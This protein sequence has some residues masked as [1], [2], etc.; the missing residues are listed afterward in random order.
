MTREE[1]IRE[2][3]LLKQRWNLIS[4]GIPKHA[5]K[6]ARSNIYVNK[7]VHGT[8]SPSGFVL[9]SKSV[10]QQNVTI[11]KPPSNHGSV[12]GSVSLSNSTSCVLPVSAEDTSFFSSF[13]ADLIRGGH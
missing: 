6:I 13:F 5:I 12:S 10:A 1:R 11:N 4:S 2:S 9:A 3:T 7:V 8:Y